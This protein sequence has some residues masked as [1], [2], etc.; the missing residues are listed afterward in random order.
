MKKI[1]TGLPSYVLDLASKSEKDVLKKNLIRIQ[2]LESEKPTNVPWY[3]RQWDGFREWQ[4]LKTCVRGF[5]AVLR[6]RYSRK[7]D[8]GLYLV[9]RSN[10]TPYRRQG[11][12]GSERNYGC[13][14]RK[15][16]ILLWV[17]KDE[18]N[19]NWYML[20]STNQLISI[21]GAELDGIE[22]IKS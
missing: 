12:W 18:L 14:L 2:K 15:G 22:L 19:N 5:R 3:S 13:R 4:S 20:S 10:I 6:K 16:E 8:N 21:R 17:E 11:R 7:M 9:R 1:N